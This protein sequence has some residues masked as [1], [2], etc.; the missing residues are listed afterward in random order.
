[1]YPIPIWPKNELPNTSKSRI[2][3]KIGC[4]FDYA[5]P[6]GWLEEFVKRHSLVLN[7]DLVLRTTVWAY[8]QEG[9]FHIFG[10]PVSCCLEVHNYIQE[11]FWNKVLLNK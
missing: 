11:E 5:L 9:P 4:T 8:P 3:E 6:E 7:S 2:F 10:V 1:M